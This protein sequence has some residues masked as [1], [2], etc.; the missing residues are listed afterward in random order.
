[1]FRARVLLID[2]DRSSRNGL[3]EILEHYNFEVVPATSV[4]EA[5]KA[6]AAQRFD[7]L[8]S[9]LH[10]PDAEDGIAMLTAMRQAQPQATTIGLSST[11]PPERPPQ[12]DHILEKPIAVKELIGLLRGDMR[13][14][15]A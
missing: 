2:L 15:Q 4:E 5:L 10:I 13:K 1:M 6:I 3:Q 12:A 11:S 14:R 9:D 7:A 8:I